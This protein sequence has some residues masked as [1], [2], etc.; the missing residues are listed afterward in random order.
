MTVPETIT[1]SNLAACGLDLAWYLAVPFFL[2]LAM[3][4]AAV[5]VALLA[6]AAARHAKRRGA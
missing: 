2:G 5:V 6:V 1:S 3:V 4:V